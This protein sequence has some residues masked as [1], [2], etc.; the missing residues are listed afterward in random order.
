MR[1]VIPLW[2]AFVTAISV[3]PLKLKYRVGT[4][5]VLHNPGHF[6]VFLITSILVC[7]GAVNPISRLFRWAGVCC[8]AV[9]MEILEWYLYHN[10]ME[11]RDVLVDFSGTVLGLAVISF[12]PVTATRIQD[13]E[14]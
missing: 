4:T 11:W 5:G 3:M 2:L 8:F 14:I 7:K 13:G 1:F 9:T 6:L 10:R 12:L